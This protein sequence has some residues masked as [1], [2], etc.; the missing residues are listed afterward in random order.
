MHLVAGLPGVTPGTPRVAEDV[1]AEVRRLHAQGGLTNVEIAERCGTTKES[2]R[3]WTDPDYARRK[4]E[5]SN[6]RRRLRRLSALA[7]Q[8][9]DVQ[10]RAED[11][12]YRYGEPGRAALTRAIRRLATVQGKDAVREACL[13]IAAIAQ[14]WAQRLGAPLTDQEVDRAA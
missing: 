9:V 11:R 14:R 4:M 5:Q 8:G 6:E 3:C 7:D 13:D 1:K 12:A 10:A 2:V